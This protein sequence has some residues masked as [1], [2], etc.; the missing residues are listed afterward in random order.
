[1]CAGLVA[2]LVTRVISGIDMAL[3]DIKGKA[4]GRPVYDL[5]GGKLRDS[6]Q[7]YTH[8]RPTNP[9][10]S[11]AHAKQLVAEGY[12]AMKTD[13]FA[14]EM[15]PYHTAYVSGMISTEGERFGADIIAATREA[16]GPNIQI[17][18]DLHGQYNVATAIRAGV[19]RPERC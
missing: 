17:L 7:L 10:D 11:A 15:A 13:P 1:M 19:Q 5:L 18:I 12:T 6:I 4:L 14:P 3:W 8:F 2:C 16:V 9:D